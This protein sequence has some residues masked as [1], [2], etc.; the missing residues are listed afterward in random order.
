M[1]AEG[2]IASTTAAA[3]SWLTGTRISSQ[4]HK[5]SD[6]AAAQH[7][8]VMTMLGAISFLCACRSAAD[9]VCLAMV[10]FSFRAARMVC[11]KGGAA[12]LFV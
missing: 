11:K 7:S 10:I 4:G 9:I 3:K 6:T 5:I 8:S 2:P 12:S 1:S